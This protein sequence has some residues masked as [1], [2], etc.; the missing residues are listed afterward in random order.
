MQWQLGRA[1]PQRPS[2]ALGFGVSKL[3]FFV[4][5]QKARLG[6]GSPAFL[7]VGDASF[8]S[9]QKAT[10]GSSSFI[11]LGRLVLQEHGDLA[12]RSLLSSLRSA[13]NLR[14]WQPPFL[15]VEHRPGPPFR[16][17]HGDLAFRSLLVSLFPESNVRQWQPTFLC[18]GDAFLG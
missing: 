18:V 8:L 9:V 17:E 5:Y 3:A 14:Q 12:L 2:G 11:G 7:G 6:S 4:M 13:C 10:L 16:Q 1:G 15:D